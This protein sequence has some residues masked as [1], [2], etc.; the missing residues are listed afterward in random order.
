MSINYIEN[1]IQKYNEEQ[2]KQIISILGH[3]DLIQ[4]IK[5][6]PKSFEKEPELRGYRIDTLAMKKIQNIYIKRIFKEQDIVLAQYIYNL[7]SDMKNTTN[8]KIS[9]ELEIDQLKLNTVNI[10]DIAYCLLDTQFK[11]NI[12]LYYI[13]NNRKVAQ[14]D[15]YALLKL[16]EFLQ[17]N[18]IREYKFKLDNYN[19]TIEN[20]KKDIEKNKN[21]LNLKEHQIEEC[22]NEIKRLKQSLSKV[23][24]ENENKIE[25]FQDRINRLD[26][27]HE[28]RYSAIQNEKN[29][30]EKQNIELIKKQEEKDSIIKNLNSLLKD[31]YNKNSQEFKKKFIKENDVL[32]KG[33]TDLKRINLDL[34]N[35][36]KE[37]EDIIENLKCEKSLIL[38]EKQEIKENINI[39]KKEAGNTVDS[40]SNIIKYLDI[41]PSNSEQKIYKYRELSE[42]TESQGM[43]E[44]RD[45]FVHALK[46][47]LTIC[48][49]EENCS[50]DL[51]EYIFAIL[52]SNSKLLFVGSKSR[53][54]TNALSYLINEKPAEIINIP[55]GYK[56]WREL[57][58]L[59]ENADSDFILIENSINNIEENIYLALIKQ[60]INKNIIFSIDSLD[61]VGALST[62]IL[63]YVGVVELDR[64]ATFEN[65]E[66]LLSG[67][68]DSEILELDLNYKEKKKNLRNLKKMDLPIRLSNITK[69]NYAEI[70]TISDFFNVKSSIYKM[71]LF[72]IMVL[73]ESNK[74][75]V[76]FNQF[77]KSLNLENDKLEILQKYIQEVEKYEE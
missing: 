13:I 69:V 60:N 37:M 26:N 32:V 10:Y 35:K 42:I 4:I 27:L 71:M 15:K 7:I 20:Y 28:E 76:E 59:I 25:E 19:N 33:N 39:L 63:N 12:E 3:K 72:G 31:E 49:I 55:I 65:N 48:G 14:K 22:N 40:I 34:Q 1:I 46:I 58:N 44:D 67:L 38:E 36:K 47:N 23:Q 57:I 11:N 6:N 29:V 64:F 17:T 61:D 70:I 54:V 66:I 30:I 16:C 41:K 2:F 74:T 18:K 9:S 43:I 77:I 62:N 21:I 51:A 56:N 5:N 73:C 75:I 45:E 8:K 52:I 50:Y 24:K 53:K 68:T